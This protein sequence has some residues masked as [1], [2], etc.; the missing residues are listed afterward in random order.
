MKAQEQVAIIK[1]SR[2]QEAMT[3]YNRGYNNFLYQRAIAGK[4]A[5]YGCALQDEALALCGHPAYRCSRR[6]WSK[7]AFRFLARFNN[8]HIIREAT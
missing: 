8:G 5:T 2:T 4:S 3:R 6:R 1:H 7:D